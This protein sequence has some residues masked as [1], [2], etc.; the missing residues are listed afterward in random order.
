MSNLPEDMTRPCSECF[1][2]DSHINNALNG[3]DAEYYVQRRREHECK[4]HGIF[5]CE[6]CMDFGC[7]N[8]S[9]YACQLATMLNLVRK[10][11]PQ[12]GRT[13][14]ALRREE[15]AHIR[16]L[17]DFDDMIGAARALVKKLDEITEATSG[18]WV[19]LEMHGMGYTGPNYAEELQK[20]KDM[21]NEQVTYEHI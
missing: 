1:G 9:N 20:V 7:S 17:A 13:R 21:I 19:Y 2:I 4:V 15:E 10:L 14:N 16:T 8:N 12:T 5:D 3:M 11:D 6:N 18:I